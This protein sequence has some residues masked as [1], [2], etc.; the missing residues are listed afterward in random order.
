[1]HSQSGGTQGIDNDFAVQSFENVGAWILGRNMFGPVRDA[2]KD[3][4]WKG[5]RGDNPPYHTHVLVLTHQAR[6]PLTID[7]GIVPFRHGWNGVCLKQAQKSA[8]AKTSESAV[9]YPLF[10]ST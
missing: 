2:W 1:M 10:V 4:S 9:E 5:W 7:G 8:K 6:P 3:D